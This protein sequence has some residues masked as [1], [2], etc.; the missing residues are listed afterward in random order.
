MAHDSL[1]VVK[2]RYLE[3]QIKNQKSSEGDYGSPAQSHNIQ[4]QDFLWHVPGASSKSGMRTRSPLLDLQTPPAKQAVIDE[5]NRL[6]DDLDRHGH[7][8]LSGL[9]TVH[10][11]P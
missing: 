4:N 1:N 2:P 8:N 9:P 6:D 11:A 3:E 5:Q 7:D 10:Y